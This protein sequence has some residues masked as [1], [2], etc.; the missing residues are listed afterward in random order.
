MT[1][2]NSME[3]LLDAALPAEA[4]TAYDARLLSACQYVTF[5]HSTGIVVT[6]YT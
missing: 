3:V 4:T 6:E 1:R 2:D 5:C